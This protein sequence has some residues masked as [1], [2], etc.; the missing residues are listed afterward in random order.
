M[1]EYKDELRQERK[2]LVDKHGEPEWQE[3]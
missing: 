1:A 2:N 3:Q